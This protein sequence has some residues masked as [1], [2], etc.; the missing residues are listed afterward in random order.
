MKFSAM[1]YHQSLFV[2]GQSDMIELGDE[3]LE[4]EDELMP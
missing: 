4:V 1:K 3:K 2:S